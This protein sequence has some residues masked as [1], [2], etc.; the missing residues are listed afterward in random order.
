[1][2]CSDCEKLFDAYLDGQLSGS[3]RLEFDA[4]RLRCPR[5]QQTLAMLEAVGDVIASDASIPELTDD[6]TER[7]MAQVA[8]PRAPRAIRFPRNRLTVITSVALQ[9]AAVL[10]FAVLWHNQTVDRNPPAP[11]PVVD[12][13]LGGREN[14]PDFQAVRELVV[15]QVEDRLWEFHAAGRQLTTDL[16]GLASYLNVT[17]PAD[18]ANESFRMAGSNPLLLLIGSLLP[19]EPEEPTTPPPIEE[20]HSI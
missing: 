5:C 11:A 16:V 8:T 7:V 3:L 20:L 13:T 14:D 9:V 18:V 6:F 19:G 1:M 15:R 2:N 12:A 4:H 10:T 17:L